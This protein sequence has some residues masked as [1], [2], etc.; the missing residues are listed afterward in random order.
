VGGS[1]PANVWREK[2]VV[3]LP[4]ASLD[5]SF[6]IN[7]HQAG[8]TCF[9][10][11]FFQLLV[12]ADVEREVL[13]P[14]TTQGLPV[15][16]ALQLQEWCAGEIIIRQSPANPVD[17]YHVGENAAIALA[18]E[19]RCVLLLDDQNPY[20]FA[21]AHN[22]KVVST[23]D[24]V[25]LLYVTGRLSHGVA[26]ATIGRLGLGKRLA[27]TALTVLAVLAERRGERQ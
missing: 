24:F 8:L 25:V 3:S 10:P 20:H 6:W 18:M 2:A 17:W 7:A 14:L 27:R 16:A 26:E 22:L 11:E 1:I 21:R 13:Y 19:N 12:C 4:K 5:A 9:L 23:A 15:P